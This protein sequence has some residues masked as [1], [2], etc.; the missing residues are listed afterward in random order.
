MSNI[1]NVF[2]VLI[3]FILCLFVGV[4][5]IGELH[6]ANTNG[7]VINATGSLVNCTRSDYD[8]LMQNNTINVSSQINLAGSYMIYILLGLALIATMIYISAL[9][10]KR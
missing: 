7:C 6:L 1:F 3:L 9:I 4:Y 8:Y 10:R 2:S 5:S